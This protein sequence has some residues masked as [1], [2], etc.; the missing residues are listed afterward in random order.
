M[1]KFFLSLAVFSALYFIGCAENSITDPDTI[2]TK[3]EKPAGTINTGRIPLKGMLVVPGFFTSYYT[4]SGEIFYKHER[5][6]TEPVPPRNN[7]TLDLTVKAELFDANSQK[8]FSWVISDETADYFYVSEEGIYLLEK[9]F[10]V[11]NR[12]D[13]LRLVCRLLV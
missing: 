1:K 12:K 4:I 7:I 11:N 8:E 3:D 2:L 13:G 10:R 5:A 6:R 9:S